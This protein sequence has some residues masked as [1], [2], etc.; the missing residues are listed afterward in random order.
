MDKCTKDACED[1]AGVQMDSVNV[2][3]LLY[4]YDAVLMFENESDLQIALNPLSGVKDRM[5]LCMSPK[6]RVKHGVTSPSDKPYRRVLT[7]SSLLFTNTGAKDKNLSYSHNVYKD[8]VLWGRY[9][10]PSTQTSLF[11][12]SLTPS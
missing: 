4:A 10:K 11:S 9:A 3:V 2:K 5:D 8:A 6:Q 1:V 7:S 12:N